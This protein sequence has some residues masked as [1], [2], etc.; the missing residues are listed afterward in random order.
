MCRSACVSWLVRSLVALFLCTATSVAQDGPWYSECPACAQHLGG[1]GVIGPFSSYAECNNARTG[2]A[3]VGFSGFSACHSGSPSS[4]S[5]RWLTPGAAVTGTTAAFGVGFGLAGS[6]WDNPQGKNF[7]LGGA[8]LGAGTFGFAA[9]AMNAR[10]MSRPVVVAVSAM[11]FGLAA[12]GAAQAIQFNHELTN[13]TAP[14][15]SNKSIVMSGAV[16]VAVGAA[17]G[18]ALPHLAGSAAGRKVQPLLR[19]MGHLQY[20]MTAQHMSMHSAR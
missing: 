1:S 10:K 19:V 8:A 9:L 15:P 12:A 20:G 7:G 4:A 17:V 3:N 16:G 6:F 18:F 11:D 14:V 2:E 13:P 5:Q